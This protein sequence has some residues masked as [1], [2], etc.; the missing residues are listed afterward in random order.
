MPRN[1]RKVE[2]PITLT[3]LSILLYN[4]SMKEGQ[5]WQNQIN[6][7]IERRQPKKAPVEINPPQISPEQ[8]EH[9]RQTELG[10]RRI[11]ETLQGMVIFNTDIAPVLSSF[12]QEVWGS[13]GTISVSDCSL[14][15]LSKR[16]AE[17]RF[18]FK[19]IALIHSLAKYVGEY[20]DVKK[21]RFG[22]R[23]VKSG[24]S[25]GG[26][27]GYD[28]TT[29]YTDVTGFY[30]D[31]GRRLVK[32]DQRE[33][34]DSISVTLGYSDMT[35]L[36]ELRVADSKTSMH[37]PDFEELSPSEFPDRIPDIYHEW[38]ENHDSSSRERYRHPFKDYTLVFSEYDYE[39]KHQVPEWVGLIFSKDT[40]DKG[41]ILNFLN[42]AL[43][44]SGAKRKMGKSLPRDIEY[45]NE[46][47][48]KRLQSRL[49]KKEFK[50]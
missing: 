27:E 35:G 40:V 42:R 43:I 9:D 12:N 22:T 33:V 46:E 2:Y 50:D 1:Y 5:T 4:L 34:T 28:V 29:I 14:R 10:N 23:S 7:E 36:F 6:G 11:V 15:N 41:R 24:A 3:D 39:V 45:K 25:S 38:C 26:I 16:G 49:G 47:E 48:L 21:I 19:S 17:K 44:V 37:P 30:W 8:L 18:G 20:E 32:I 31:F 13:L